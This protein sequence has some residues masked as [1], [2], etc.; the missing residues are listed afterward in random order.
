M[1]VTL[2]LEGSQEQVCLIVVIDIK[3]PASVDLIG[4][5]VPVGQG[6]FYPEVHT[7]FPQ[8]SWASNADRFILT[9]CEVMPYN[10]SPEDV[11]QNE[12]R[13]QLTL[14]RGKDFFGSPSFLYPSTGVFPLEEGK[15]YYWQIQTVVSS[16]S[17]D[18]FLPGE[19]FV[20]K[21]AKMD[22][23]MKQILSASIME[24]FIAILKGTEYEY[25]LE[26]DGPIAGYMPS[27]VLKIKG[28]DATIYDLNALLPDFLAK[29]KKVKGVTIEK[30][31]E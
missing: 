4:P 24:A 10:A 3:E 26:P 31:G 1:A 13:A 21:M 16:P 28:K 2:S 18:I 12:P 8:F 22:A 25:V 27:G 6:D 23:A 11:M 30:I 20:F 19:I 14:E 17:G 29:I 5:G 9:V 7:D 15:T